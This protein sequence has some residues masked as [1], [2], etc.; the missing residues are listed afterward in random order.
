M[1]LNA[2][3]KLRLRVAGDALFFRTA[4]GTELRNAREVVQI[5]GRAVYELLERLAPH[6]D[7]SRTLDELTAT[8]PEAKRAAVLQICEGLVRRGMLREANDARGAVPE[9]WRSAVDFIDHFADTAPARF[10]AFR[11]RRVAAAGSGLPRLAIVHAL[12]SLGVARIDVT[13]DE[14]RQRIAAYGG[15]SDVR[16]TEAIDWSS[17]DNVVAA[18]DDAAEIA[19]LAAACAAKRVALFAGVIGG[20]RAI[21]GAEAEGEGCLQ[22]AWSSVRRDLAPAAGHRGAIGPAAAAI[23]ANELVFELFRRA[24]RVSPPL[25]AHNVLLVEIAT[26]SQSLFRYRTSPDCSVCAGGAARAALAT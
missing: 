1:D 26:L 15:A 9:A 7:G 23:L 25:F 17:V 18:S 20:G 4:G 22:C 14:H 19:E 24:T 10:A 6:L 2:V 5:R 12:I 21:A 11:E 13:G 8:L 3:G 16:V